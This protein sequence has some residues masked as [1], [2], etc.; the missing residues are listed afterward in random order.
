MHF[1]R[2]K[3][4]PS[5]Q[6]VFLD[7]LHTYW[8]SDNQGHLDDAEYC[9][10]SNSGIRTWRQWPEDPLWDI[11]VFRLGLGTLKLHVIYM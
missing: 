4:E 5:K 6:S 9:S 3:L 8:V 7:F 1:V 11:F 2:Y 10:E